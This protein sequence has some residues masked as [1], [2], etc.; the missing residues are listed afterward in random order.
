[1]SAIV[2]DSKI[3][4]GSSILVARRLEE[5]RRITHAIHDID[6]THSLIRD[7]PPVMSLSMCYAMTCGF[8]DGFDSDENLMKLVPK[9]GQ[10]I[11]EFDEITRFFNGYS[12]ITQ[13][14]YG[15]RRGIEEGMIP[16][17]RL[18][19]NSDDRKANSAILDVLRS[20]EERYP[21]IR[22]RKHVA[23]FIDS[24]TPALFRFY[25]NLLY[26]ASRDKHI[27]DARSNPARWRVP[28]SLEFIS[29]LRDAGVV[30]YFVTGAVVYEG[31]GMRE[32]VEVCGYEI[33]Q[34]KLIE[35]LE[36]SSW[37]EKMPKN[38]VMRKIFRDRNL[39][40]A[41]VLIL[42]DGRTEIK[43]AAEMG[44]PSISRLPHEDE[45]QRR[46]HIALG[47]NYIVPDYTDTSLK[48]MIYKEA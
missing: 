16:E 42:G 20:G 30:N 48:K 25:E 19:L 15:I 23:D 5:P 22:E 10:P 28:G 11:A 4:P 18:P 7:W 32:E 14:E 41:N 24:V 47:V 12:A 45:R 2:D 31:G 37:D 43:S 1:M 13:L 44:C 6:G 39:A 21:H 35:S 17:A 38:E 8:S 29:H 27:E 9:V 26:K 36:G 40:P 46:L 33:G 34:G 3:I